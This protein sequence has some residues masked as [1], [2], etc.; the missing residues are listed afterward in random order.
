MTSVAFPATVAPAPVALATAPAPTT[1]TVERPSY[2]GLL[3]VW[4]FFG[5]LVAGGLLALT[6][7]VAATW[8]VLVFMAS[9]VGM[10]GTSALYHRVDW[11]PTWYGRMRRLDHAMIFAFIVGTQTPL[12]MITLADQGMEWTFYGMLAFAAVGFL[13]TMFWV[14]A[15]KWVRALIYIVVGWS[16]VPAL[17]HLID[18]I[19]GWGL[20]LLLL[21]GVLYSVGGLVYGLK[22]PNPWPDRFGYHELF[23]AFV[24]AAAA[25][26]FVVIAVW[27]CA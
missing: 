8:P 2:R 26:H 14:E 16:A 13:V 5:F 1:D 20:G 27:V 12:F 25:T 10:M 9:V 22:R 7:P 4:G 24:L 17:G 18:A 21:G 23:H 15:P 6:H 19:G 11:S 3:C